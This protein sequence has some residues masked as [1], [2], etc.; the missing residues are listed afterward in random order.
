M[1]T[2]Y[3]VCMVHRFSTSLQIRKNTINFGFIGTYYGLITSNSRM[4]HGPS[5]EDLIH[6]IHQDVFNQEDNYSPMYGNS[7]VSTN[8]YPQNGL[9]NVPAVTNSDFQSGNQMLHQDV[10]SYKI[11]KYSIYSSLQYLARLKISCL[12]LIDK[13][14][15]FEC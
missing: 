9:W 6:S 15:L 14:Y 1:A 2:G 3:S 4:E 12:T 10:V 11:P 5:V 8:Q 13:Y 7:P